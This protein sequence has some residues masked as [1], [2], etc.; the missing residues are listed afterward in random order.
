MGMYDELKVKQDLPLPEELKNFN[1]D[2]KNYIFQTKDLDNCLGEYF[3]SEDGF[4]YEHIIEREYIPYTEEEKR[5]KNHRG[6]DIYKEVIEKN[7]YDKKID[8]YHG[9]I[10]FGAYDKL[11]DNEHDFW[12]DFDAYFV[13]GKLD[14]ITLVEFK[15]IISRNVINEFLEKQ[16]LQ[17]E[18]SFWCFFKRYAS[19]LGWRWFWRKISNLFYKTSKLCTSIQFFI[20]KH[21]L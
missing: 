10:R 6:W 20:I 4:L 18:K 16:R 3:I 8:D 9:K 5:N 1:R 14:K 11:N 21:I 13:Y 12:I 2:W 19:Y 15:K 7:S 17:K